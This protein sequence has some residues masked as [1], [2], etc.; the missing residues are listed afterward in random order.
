MTEQETHEPTPEQIQAMVN[1]IRG[2]YLLS[3]ALH[4]SIEA[5]EG[6][7]EE[8][9][10]SSNIEDMKY[11]YMY[12]FP[13]FKIAR[14]MEERVGSLPDFIINPDEGVAATTPFKKGD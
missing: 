14:D 13:L 8:F 10:E 1:G 6:V 9:R 4:Y 2:Q 3:Q 12:A 7:E 11:L 5:L